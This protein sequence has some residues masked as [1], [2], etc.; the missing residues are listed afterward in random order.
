M[1][2]GKTK[3][4]NGVARIRNAATG[5]IKNNKTVRDLEKRIEDLEQS[6]INIYKDMPESFIEG[7]P[8]HTGKM[9]WIIGYLQERFGP[10]VGHTALADARY[11]KEKN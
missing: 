5:E 7:W 8:E 11:P 10:I 1:K 6:M 4:P 2:E 9:H 3:I